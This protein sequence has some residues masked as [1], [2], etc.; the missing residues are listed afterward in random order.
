MSEV[1]LYAVEAKFNDAKTEY[2]SL[3]NTLD[4]ACLGKEKSSK[5]CRKAAQL[6]AEMQT[7]LIQMSNLMK[8]TPANL[9]KQQELLNVANQLGLDMGGLLT[10]TVQGKEME[11]MS[12]MYKGHA[13]A[14]TI[15]AITVFLLIVYTWKNN[16]E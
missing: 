10:E 13:V 15:S 16:T 9:P 4:T 6:N 11:L 8:K 14:W 2:V 7:Y 1:D 3:L 12:D 5:Q